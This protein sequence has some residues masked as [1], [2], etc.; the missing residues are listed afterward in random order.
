VW[1]QYR[2]LFLLRFV[3][4]DEENADYD[5]LFPYHIEDTEDNRI[6]WIRY[7]AVISVYE[8]VTDSEEIIWL[9]LYP[10]FCLNNKVSICNRCSTNFKRMRA[11]IFLLRIEWILVC[12]HEYLIPL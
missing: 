12:G 11:Q 2:N 8:I 3:Y 9:Y 6:K 7:R 10:A 1:L 4:S 5:L